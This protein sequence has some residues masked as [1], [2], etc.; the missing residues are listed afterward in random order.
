MNIVNVKVQKFNELNKY[1]DEI[2]CF[3]LLYSGNRRNSQLNYLKRI[4]LEGF[5]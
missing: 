5:F 3:N 2:Y 4:L 1:L